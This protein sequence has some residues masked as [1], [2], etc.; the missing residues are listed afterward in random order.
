MPAP[1]VTTIISLASQAAGLLQHLVPGAGLDFGTLPS[2][3][4]AAARV[5]LE[6]PDPYPG[7]GGQGAAVVT[8]GH[9]LLTD[10]V[11]IDQ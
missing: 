5:K 4:A 10:V 3:F 9:P 8:A 7:R 1:G 11:V 2:A 6:L